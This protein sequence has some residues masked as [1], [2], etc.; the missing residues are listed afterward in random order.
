MSDMEH[1]MEE[2][3]EALSRAVSDDALQEL[4]VR[5]LGKKGEITAMMK[6]ISRTIP[7]ERTPPTEFFAGFE[8]VVF[9]F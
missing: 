5:Y 2:I 8:D 6:Q 4:R 1:R 9:M 3:R 7:A